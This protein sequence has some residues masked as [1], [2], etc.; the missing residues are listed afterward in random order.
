MHAP[1][2]LRETPPGRERRA[3]PA[4]GSGD[5]PTPL[6]ARALALVLLVLGANLWASYHLGIGLDNP[7][8]IAG[9]VAVVS[10]AVALVEKLFGESIGDEAQSRMQSLTR[11][12]LSP[13][14]IVI[15]Y[16]AALIVMLTTSSVMVIAESPGEGS[17]VTVAPLDEPDA[18]R[19]G[20]VGSEGDLAR[21]FVLSSPFGRPFRVTASG[22]V[23]ATFDVYPFV[24]RKVRLGTDLPVSPSVLFRPPVL[25]LRSLG[26]GGSFKVWDA[27]NPDEPI[28]AIAGTRSSF[29]LGRRYSLPAEWIG[30]WELELARDLGDEPAMRPMVAET[31]LEWKRPT[32][33]E[34]EASVGPGSTLIA[35]VWTRADKVAARA[36]VTLGTE[37]LID[38]P[39]REVE[40]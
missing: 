35:E 38:V 6:F 2:P 18:T 19:D 23:P 25:A 24:G 14:V 33:L 21:F 36:E 26:G 17:R 30:D 3:R 16:L 12:A 37:R 34:S 15:L 29:L 5:R 39:M 20:S 40:R 31:L 4:P 13:A 7:G 11:S 1:Q 8:W 32:M 22:Y 28:A 27:A 10:G 9:L